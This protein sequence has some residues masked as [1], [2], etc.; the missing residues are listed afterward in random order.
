MRRRFPRWPFVVLG[1]TGSIAMGKST[2]AAMLRNLRIP[3]ID[4]DAAVH[5]LLGP[6]GAAV[7]AVTAKFSGVGD[8]I[9]GIDRKK[10]GAH[11]FAN[12]QDLSVL[13]AILHP[14]V[15][16]LR[17]AALRQAAFRR[18]P[19]VA[20]DTPLLF[21]SGGD[22]DCDAVMVIT[23]PAFLQRQRALARPGMTSAKFASILKRQMPD[24]E[25]RRRADAVIP[26]SLGRRETLSQIKRFLARL[27]TRRVRSIF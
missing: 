18:A 22:Q 11:V 25:K 1:L 2:A 16:T 26:S 6:R 19:I 27:Q 14:A 12:P 21:E 7:A 20:L 9:Q 15:R 17:S 8:H 23:A 5:K 13:E 3:V 10:L 24:A 4:A